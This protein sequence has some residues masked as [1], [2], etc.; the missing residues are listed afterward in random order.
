[1]FIIIDVI[2]QSLTSKLVCY[3]EITMLNYWD[4]YLSSNFSEHSVFW[5]VLGVLREKGDSKPYCIKRCI[6]TLREIICSI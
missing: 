4:Q 1:M 2:A 5:G 3:L 6:G